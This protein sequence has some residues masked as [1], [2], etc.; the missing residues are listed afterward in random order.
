MAQTVEICLEDFKSRIPAL[1]PYVEFSEEGTLE[2]HAA[3]DSNNGCYGKI[4]DNLKIPSDVN[5]IVYISVPEE[6]INQA[7]TWNETNTIPLSIDLETFFS[8]SCSKYLRKVVHYEY[9][10]SENCED[11]VLVDVIPNMLTDD[12]PNC[13]KTLKIGAD[14]SVV[15]CEGVVLY[16]YYIK[17]GYYRYYERKEIIK[18]CETYSYRTIISSYYK[19]RNIVGEQNAFIGFV[20]NGIGYVKVNRTLLNLEDTNKYPEVP[21]YIYLSQIK[22]LKSVY[23]DYKEAYEQYY[24][25]QN[26][27]T[28]SVRL[29]NKAETYV[30]MGGDNFTNWLGQMYQKAYDIANYYK[31]LAE[32]KDYPVRFQFFTQLCKTGKVVGIEN[33]C[34]NIFVGGNRY[35][36]GDILTYEGKTY[37]CKLDKIVPNGN[38]YNYI[39]KN[40]EIDGI[41]VSGLFMLNSNQS[42]Y[43]LI[44]NSNIYYLPNNLSFPEVL[45]KEYIVYKEQFYRWIQG[46]YTPINVTKYSTGIWNNETKNFDFDFQHFVP[47]SEISADENWYGPNNP[48]GENF[49]YFADVEYIPTVKTCE[50][51][52][53]NNSIFQWDELENAYVPSEGNENTIYETTDSKLRGLRTL[54]TYVNVDGNAEEPG[55]DED[56]LYFYHVGNITSIITETDSTGNIISDSLVLFVGQTCYDLHAYG[57]IIDSITYNEENNTITFVYVIGAHLLAVFDGLERDADGNLKKKYRDFSYDSSSNDGVVFTETY[58]CKD[59]S[60]R[61]LGEDFDM[62]VSG[63]ITTMIEYSYQ[64]FPFITTPLLAPDGSTYIE[65]MGVAHLDVYANMSHLNTVKKEWELGLYHQ[66]KVK[67]NAVVDRG[68]GAS[69][70]RHI[71]LGEIHSMEEMV[72]YQNGSYYRLSEK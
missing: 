6:T 36:D 4:V 28:I 21:D 58:E 61:N 63:D 53:F 65:G 69:F 22:Q 40:I 19:Y 8:T 55:N 24:L 62:Y 44:S 57:N 67:N 72:S 9:V 27:G 42:E 23:E 54:K 10:K 17:T 56:W 1:F 30:R 52:R 16:D 68:N 18:P 35:Y 14:G 66:P 3:T 38:N 60:I 25:Q 13:V 43:V 70:E 32:Q 37:I 47:I 11:S 64:K 7:Y 39:C 50:Y 5:L 31:C 48:Y 41:F 45:I 33:V 46:T 59:D 2:T 71:R 49:K 34:E 26:T 15:G 12:S 20:E 29:K 51:I